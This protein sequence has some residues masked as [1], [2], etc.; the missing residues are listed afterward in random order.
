MPARDI[1]LAPFHADSSQLYGIMGTI[2]EEHYNSRQGVIKQ[3]LIAQL[4]LGI[5][6]GVCI[7]NS[8]QT[9]FKE[10]PQNSTQ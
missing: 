4:C 6:K 2:W 5:K 3:R 7:Q 1:L 8:G 10:A 9:F